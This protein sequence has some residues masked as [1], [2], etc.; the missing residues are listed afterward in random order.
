M[1]IVTLQNKAN[2]FSFQCLFCATF[3]SVLVCIV[4]FVRS[5]NDFKVY[6]VKKRENVEGIG[7]KV[8]ENSVCEY[9][10]F[11][12]VTKYSRISSQIGNLLIIFDIARDSL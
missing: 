6:T 12:K 8:I 11:S 10:Y 4:T 7:F 9:N 1:E 3:L 5:C 2:F